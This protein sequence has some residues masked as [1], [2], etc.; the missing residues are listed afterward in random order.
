MI[1]FISGLVQVDKRFDDLK[2]KCW[3]LAFFSPL[4]VTCC[5]HNNKSKTLH[6]YTAGLARDGDMMLNLYSIYTHLERK[7]FMQEKLAYKTYLH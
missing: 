1:D 3:Y 5:R 7:G 6:W 2:Q 4:I